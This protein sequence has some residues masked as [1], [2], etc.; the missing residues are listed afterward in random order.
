D[1]NAAAD[2]AWR[3]RPP[4][5][6]ATGDVVADARS[7]ADR[8][9]AW[10]HALG[11]GADQAAVARADGLP[12]S[13]AQLGLVYSRH[14]E[15]G[16]MDGIPPAVRDMANRLTLRRIITSGWEEAEP[17]LNWALEHKLLL[18]AA[19]EQM[20]AVPD[21]PGRAHLLNYVPALY[22]GHPPL[23]VE[24][25]YGDI[26]AAR[27][28]GVHLMTA[29]PGAAAML[30][31]TP[32]VFGHYEQLRGQSPEPVAVVMR[33]H[34]ETMHDPPPGRTDSG[35]LRE[36]DGRALLG[37][38][39]GRHV[40][41]AELHVVA[42]P[43]MG[44]TVGW[45]SRA[46]SLADAGV[47][48]VTLVRIRTVDPLEH[49]AQLGVD[50]VFVLPREPQ[51][52]VDRPPDVDAFQSQQYHGPE[53]RDPNPAGA[54]FGARELLEAGPA[55]L[56]EI[57][58]GRH[59]GDSPGLT[60]RQL[61]ERLWDRVDAGRPWRFEVP[62]ETGGTRMV[63]AMEAAYRTARAHDMAQELG[64]TPEQVREVLLEDGLDGQAAAEV[65]GVPWEL[66]DQIH[67]RGDVDLTALDRAAA[68]LPGAPPVRLIG[69][70]VVAIGH[71][72]Q[73]LPG[74]VLVYV[75]EGSVADVGARAAELYRMAVRSDPERP[76]TVVACTTAGHTG[77]ELAL[78][79]A[80]LEG[81][82][83]LR[84]KL[85]RTPTPEF[86]LVGEGP[87]AARLGV[88]AAGGRLDHHVGSL[89]F[90]DPPAGMVHEGYGE[91]KVYATSRGGSPES[92]DGT[93]RLAWNDDTIADIVAER[94]TEAPP[95]RSGPL[96]V[97][98]MFAASRWL[99]DREI[100]AAQ[101][102]AAARAWNALGPEPM[103]AADPR[104]VVAHARA[105]AD[106]V[107]EWWQSFDDGSGD[108]SPAQI[109]L[110]R[111]LP[112]EI[113]N[114]EGVPPAARDVANRLALRSLIAEAWNSPD[115][116]GG[117]LLERY[118]AYKDLVDTADAQVAAA[119]G[120][121][122]HAYLLSLDLPAPDMAQG[123]AGSG[124]LPSPWTFE[125]AYGDLTHATTVGVHVV[126]VGSRFEEVAF[127]L[128]DA[129]AHYQRLAL[130]SEEPVAV[131]FRL[132]ELPAEVNPLPTAVRTIDPNRIPEAEGRGLLRDLASRHATS[133][134]A[135]GPAVHLVVHGAAANAAAYAARGGGLGQAGVAR[136]TFRH[137]FEAGP[138]E[139]RTDL[140]VAQVFAEPMDLMMA[141]A[142]AMLG[143]IGDIAP[144]HPDFG[145]TYLPDLSPD[146]LA[147]ISAGY[148]DQVAEPAPDLA[149]R[150]QR[151]V[152]DGRPGGFE[153]HV[154][155][156]DAA[157]GWAADLDG[158]HHAAARTAHT[159]DAVRDLG[160]T[161]R[162]AWYAADS[163]SDEARNTA[164]LPWQVRSDL[165]ERVIGHQRMRWLEQE[166]Q[167]LPGAPT[168]YVLAAHPDGPGTMVAFGDPA[169]ESIAVYVGGRDLD[170]AVA[171]AAELYRAA[172]AADPD[173][174]VAVIASLAYSGDLYSGGPGLA[175]QLA[176]LAGEARYR[177]LR[178]GAPVPQ[179]HV[180]G[181]GL[182]AA[183][184]SSAGTSRRLQPFVDSITYIDPE[185][186]NAHA[187]SHNVPVSMTSR[188][189]AEVAEGLGGKRIE[190]SD[191]VAGKVVHGRG[192]EVPVHSGAV[193]PYLDHIEVFHGDLSDIAFTPEQAQAVYGRPDAG[194]GE[195]GRPGVPNDCAVEGSE[196]LNDWHGVDESRS[197]ELTPEV[198]MSGV[199]PARFAESVGADWSH[200]FAT[201]DDAAKYVEENG[202]TLAVAIEFRG[203]AERNNGAGAHIAVFFQ[204][205]HGRV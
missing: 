1:E 159:Y 106:R 114:L 141:Q 178:T 102:E 176:G 94:A 133:A 121:R 101:V 163:I 171:G 40:G 22:E 181:E 72:T 27:R 71:Q 165:N 83:T 116:A 45:A 103:V 120:D 182:G 4:R 158:V 144:G 7:L 70:D 20:A 91:M 173:R 104:A 166:A 30:A 177:A 36:R 57:S 162:Q 48:R 204:D 201:L 145:A 99:V 169:A 97:D 49:A 3:N 43:G 148:Y 195:H 80:G 2:A 47:R 127:A 118:L 96:G 123:P 85:A 46:G 126:P 55:T 185:G 139:H 157:G 31:A 168:A 21:G 32:E 14:R 51:P 65:P 37:S 105:D 16:G 142:N 12:L 87:G 128:P 113:G 203:L 66:R 58:L 33:K 143:R 28:A 154:D 196:F 53:Q 161:D 180:V 151:A 25:A 194:E 92:A 112:N 68:D 119:T 183:A 191:D 13:E 156:A 130:M 153:Q 86:H 75:G 129:A 35:L 98:A 77:P 88:A 170:H 190:W 184:V 132:R 52:P 175:Q 26:A 9:A 172:K 74:S 93:T 140:P 205:E 90:I 29:Q 117:A 82:I 107:A 69:R 73:G 60:Q 89:T 108:L 149:L 167:R 18:D 146:T 10:W 54:G 198:A 24:I 147:G 79:V 64:M 61:R 110:I 100:T 81:E 19:D 192:H 131:V 15:L 8:A 189:G 11:D 41:A 160:L 197:I 152:I 202:G 134:V 109:G 193:D 44:D 59:D 76:I 122:D 138:A 200:R 188:A 137:A 124:D 67:R 78:R 17:Q 187:D 111:A 164:G 174:P 38:L 62:D 84:S 50:Q 135:G 136:L 63:D 42:Q 150:L 125:L 34:Q 179:I 5:N 56:A 39:A 6:P 95:D 199:D 115:P 155:T 23:T 186:L